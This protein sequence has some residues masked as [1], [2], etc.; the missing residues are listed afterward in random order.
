MKEYDT[1]IIGSREINGG[2]LD[3]PDFPL[4][5]QLEL[6]KKAN[7]EFYFRPSYIIKKVSKI[8]NFSD[9]TRNLKAVAEI[10]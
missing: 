8:R 5:R 10:I 1:D 3:R 6:C 2:A 7:K 9:V 4:E